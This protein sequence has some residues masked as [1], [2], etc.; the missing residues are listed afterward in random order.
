MNS[1]MNPRLAV[2]IVNGLLAGRAPARHW[3]LLRLL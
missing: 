1:P 2:W 3:P